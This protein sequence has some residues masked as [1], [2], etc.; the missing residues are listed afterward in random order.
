MEIDFKTGEKLTM[1]TSI[2]DGDGPVYSKTSHTGIVSTDDKGWY[3][4]CGSYRTPLYEDTK[5]EERYGI[6][7]KY[8]VHGDNI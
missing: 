5:V 4:D 8:K 1:F 7:T 6:Y 3:L 2:K